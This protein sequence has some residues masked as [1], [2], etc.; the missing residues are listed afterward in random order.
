MLLTRAQQISTRAGSH[1]DRLQEIALVVLH[2][3]LLGPGANALHHHNLDTVLIE[4]LSIRL[5]TN[6]A[7]LQGALVDAILPALKIRFAHD[8]KELSAIAAAKGQRK[9]SL[10]TLSHMSRLSFTADRPEKDYI[11]SHFPQPPPQLLQCLMKGIRSRSSRSLIDK[12]VHFLTECLPLYLGVIFQILLKLVECLC[13]EISQAYHELQVLFRQPED[14]P[15]DRSEHVTIALLAALEN[16]IATAHDRLLIEEA[17]A[18]GNKSPD[19]PQSF[20]GNMVSGVFAAEASQTRSATANDRLT[21]LL[22]FQDAVRLCYSIWAWGDG[23]RSKNAQYPE[24][25]ASFQYTSLRMRNRSRR[26]LEHL[27]TAETLECLETLIELWGASVDN[28]NHAPGR[29]IFNLL[30]TLEGS[31]PKVAIPA[32]FNAIYSRTNPTAL[33]PSRKSAM[34]SR[35][36]E[37]DLAAFLVIYA[38]TLEEDVLDEIWT[39]CTTF[40]RDVLSNPFPHR[41]IL[42]RLL[43][44]AAILGEKME[45]TTF[46]E[47]QRAKKDLGVSRFC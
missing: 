41:H 33:D 16:C 6:E 36:T 26:I 28:D 29:S 5:D 3:L 2:Q 30:H 42:P 24:C 37:A 1:G 46:G 9:S 4:Q 43:E 23:E 39:D 17:H 11:I 18:S 21:V 15:H 35:L 40:L 38:K 44:F 25:E 14:G 27:F 12:W 19:Q 7:F 8:T 34:T 45:H 10:E 31:R 22:C 20:F 32:I 47:D 13:K